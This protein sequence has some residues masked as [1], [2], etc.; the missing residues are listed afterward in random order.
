MAQ[1]A[2]NPRQL[3]DPVML[4]RLSSIFRSVF[5]R[6]VIGVTLLM[7][8]LLLWRPTSTEFIELKLYDLKFRVRGSQPASQDVVILGIDDDSLSA[9]AVSIVKDTTSRKELKAMVEAVNEYG[10]Y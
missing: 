2:I 5:V 3:K 7:S 9:E 6:W 1:Q 8:V 10:Y 4:R